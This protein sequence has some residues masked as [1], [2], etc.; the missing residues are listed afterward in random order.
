MEDIKLIRFLC[1]IIHEL[2]MIRFLFF[3]R[4]TQEKWIDIIINVFSRLANEGINEWSLDIYGTGRLS[5]LC[6]NIATK[7]ESIHYHGRGDQATIHTKL[8]QI[9]YC[10]APSRVIETFWKSALESLSQWAEVISF[11]KGWLWQFVSD[12]LAI[13]ENNPQESLYSICKAIITSQTKSKRERAM[14][15]AKKYSK[16]AR[17]E[18]LRH[19]IW[20]NHSIMYISDFISKIGWIETFLRESKELLD[21]NWYDVAMFWSTWKVSPRNL[22]STA[23]NISA[24]FRLHKKINEWHPDVLRYHSIL[25]YLGPIVLYGFSQKTSRRQPTKKYITVHDLWL[26]HPYPAKLTKI[27]DIPPFSRK[28]FLSYGRW[29]LAKWLICLKFFSLSLLRHRLIKII[30]I[31]FVPSEFLVDILHKSR[32]VPKEKII[33]LP[34]FA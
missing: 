31:W 22:I 17:I 23:C 15:L 13:D 25:R 26:F 2:F 8:Q 19:T 28:N 16:I 4:T 3:G 34:H 33:V 27:D 1:F 14:S 6:K 5:S 30:D 29:P 20:A 11:Q 32:W 18:K 24:W 21:A 7:H 12:E 10:I 9:D